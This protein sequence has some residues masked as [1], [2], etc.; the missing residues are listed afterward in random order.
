MEGEAT[1]RKRSN[2]VSGECMIRISL[3]FWLN[4]GPLFVPLPSHVSLGFWLLL[5]RL[6]FGCFR[7]DTSGGVRSL[8]RKRPKR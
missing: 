7:S 3:A 2:E 1:L 8:T 5:Q 6:L 4:Q